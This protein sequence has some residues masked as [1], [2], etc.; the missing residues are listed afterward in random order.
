[1]SAALATPPETSQLERALVVG[2]GLAHAAEDLALQLDLPSLDPIDLPPVVGTE[3]DQTRLR[4]IPP[5]Y[6]A[7]ELEAAQLLPAA[8]AFAGIF[9]SG[10][11]GADVGPAADRV[12]AFWRG[13]HDRFA[14]EERRAFFARLFGGPG[15]VLAGHGS[16]N[17]AFEGLLLEVA[18]ALAELQPQP[19]LQPLP[20]A[21]LTLRA[22]ASELAEN[23][24][25]RTSGIPAPTARTILQAIAE[26][27]ALFKEP[28]I[29]AALGTRSPWAA[30]HAAAQR[31]RQVEPWIE[32]HVRRGKGGMVVLA[33][34]A[35][36]V[37]TLDTSRPLAQPDALTFAAAVDWL[38]GSLALQQR[39]PA[40]AA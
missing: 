20:A 32:E 27:L 10:G 31:Y 1:V 33:W 14:P 7:S 40:V 8:E 18:Q 2:I 26:A 38:Q 39:T 22:A 4:S 23:L 28:A 9:V 35:E 13:R 5:L 12:V 29:Q 6:L 21:E 3:A 37:T 19:G 30:V 25:S 17:D 36:A 34:L 24:A 16:A 15:P 11:I